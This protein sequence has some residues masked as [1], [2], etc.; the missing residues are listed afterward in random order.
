MRFTVDQTQISH[1]IPYKMIISYKPLAH[2]MSCELNR[3]S[4]EISV[5]V[6]V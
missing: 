5:L 4:T 1:E 3:N 6:L 2:E